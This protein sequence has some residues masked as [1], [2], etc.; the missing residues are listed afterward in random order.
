MTHFEVKL[1]DGSKLSFPI[2]GRKPN[3]KEKAFILETVEARERDLAAPRGPGGGPEAV[4]RIE[5]L[6]GPTRVAPPGAAE[7]R[8]EPGIRRDLGSRVL[9]RIL[10]MGLGMA[11]SVAGAAAG[12]KTGAIA[13]LGGGPIGAAIGATAGGALGAGGGQL[14]QDFLAGQEQRRGDVTL[15]E[16]LTQP[17]T[18]GGVATAT[19]SALNEMALDAAFAGPLEALQPAFRAA[20]QRFVAAD[21]LP[22]IRRA[23][24]DAR[25]LGIEFA[26]ENVSP[27]ALATGYRR[28][29]GIFPWI[30]KGFKQAEERLRKQSRGAVNKVLEAVAPGETIRRLSLGTRTM[31]AKRTN[32]LDDALGNF[33]E[34]LIRRSEAMGEAGRVTTTNFRLSGREIARS[35]RAGLG[36][37]KVTVIDEVSGE[38]VEKL[39]PIPA[40]LRKPVEK[41]LSKFANIEDSI[42]LRQYQNIGT[43][44]A[45]LQNM[46]RDKG[47]VFKDL[48][49]FSL[50]HKAMAG[51]IV[52]EGLRGAWR[53]A[54]NTFSKLRLLEDSPV[55][56]QFPAVDPGIFRGAQATQDPRQQTEKLFELVMRHADKSVNGMRQ[57]RDLV[58]PEQF[59]LFVRGHLDNAVDLAIERVGK[60]QLLL[61]TSVLRKQL[62]G[63]GP[64]DNKYQALRWAINQTPLARTLN[65][66]GRRNLSGIQQIERLVTLLEKASDQGI[67]NVSQFVARRASLGGARGVL[68][69]LQPGASIAGAGVMGAGV[70]GGAAAGGGI[71]SLAGGLVAA[72]LLRRTGMLLTDPAVLRDSI[73]ALDDATPP[74]AKAT[75][76]GRLARRLTQPVVGSGLSRLGRLSAGVT[77]NSA[78][79]RMDQLKRDLQ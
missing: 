22:E 12:A 1:S 70:G 62:L 37:K 10:R 4:A 64:R 30:G 42:T 13:G 44:I 16:S 66:A 19:R 9:G 50:A 17:P 26:A 14:L 69:A 54:N 18:A 75:L 7:M 3:P 47:L 68:R 60:D 72:L 8:A 23:V 21:E 51:D 5:D 20:Q 61:N 28:V 38:Q 48:S 63:E 24:E 57:L 53:N 34:E 46:F 58:G 67:I 71:G 35:I 29:A 43:E 73:R 78:S 6:A 52:D 65:A 40:G 36:R 76:V 74:E 25:E 55:G 27:R 56:R 33:Y 39:V 31:A 59:N 2:K 15:G 41:F 45:N 79:E 32:A 11:G 49:D 77:A